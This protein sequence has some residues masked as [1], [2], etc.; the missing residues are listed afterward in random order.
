MD[1]WLKGTPPSESGDQVQSL[2]PKGPSLLEQCCGQRGV[3]RACA[4]LPAGMSFEKLKAKIHGNG[5]KVGFSTNGAATP[6]HPQAKN[7]SRHR[8]Y[9]IHKN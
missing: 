4:G 2:F 7:E 9:T 6:G 1:A 3:F 8:P 5:A